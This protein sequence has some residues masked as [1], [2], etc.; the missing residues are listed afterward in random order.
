MNAT[1]LRSELTVLVASVVAPV[2]ML[3]DSTEAVVKVDCCAVVLDLVRSNV[4]LM[5]GVVD[6]VP[7]EGTTS[8]FVGLKMGW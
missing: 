7:V 6:N 3:V 5:S 2:L 1:L 4:M 8:G